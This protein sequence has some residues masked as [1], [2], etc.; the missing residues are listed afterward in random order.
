MLV[1]RS[2]DAHIVYNRMREQCSVTKLSEACNSRQV[3]RENTKHDPC[4][5]ENKEDSPYWS[6]SKTR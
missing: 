5:W 2:F 4:M 6:F 3:A 1:P